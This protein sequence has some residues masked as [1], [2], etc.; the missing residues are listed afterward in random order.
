MQCPHANHV[1]QKCTALLEPSSLQFMLDEIAKEGHHAIRSLAQH[2]YACRVLEGL[3]SRCPSGQLFKIVGSLLADATNL[4]M[5]RYG[6]FVMQ[7]LL[8]HVG[9]R[10][11]VIRA[12]EV[13]IPE[14]AGN[15]FG[16]LV[17]AHVLRQTPQDSQAAH[18]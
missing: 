18:L 7:Q 11:V 12:L 5:Y 9:W 15:F 8:E 4:C 10:Q 2:R 17:L 13:N 16:S 1:L 14:V 6:N 3:I